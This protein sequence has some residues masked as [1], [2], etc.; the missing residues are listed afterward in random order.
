PMLIDTGNYT[1]P[2]NE[3]EQQLCHIWQAV[4]GLD[5][6]GIHD[7]FFRIGG[8]SINAIRLIAKASTLLDKDFSL[9]ELFTYPTV[10]GLSHHLQ[11]MVGSEVLLI[12]SRD[13]R[14]LSPL[15]FAQERLWFLER[16]EAGSDTYHMPYLVQL[17]ST[18]NAELLLAAINQLAQRHPVLNSVYLEAE[19]GEGYTQERESPLK[20]Q[21]QQ[22]ASKTELEQSVRLEIQTSFNLSEQAPLRLCRYDVDDSRY[23]LLMWHHIAFDGWSTEIFIDELMEFYQ[24]LDA[25]IEPELTELSISYSDF[26]I[27]QR[28]YLQG[29]VLKGQL[30][31]WRA[32]LADIE[33]LN[34]PTDKTR[35]TQVDYCGA[36]FE[37]VLAVSLSNDLRAL[38]R[39]QNT[40]L[41]TVMLSAFYLTLSQLCHQ[42]DIIVGAPSDNRHL[43]QTQ[44]LIGFFVNSLA[45][46][47][48]V[49]PHLTCSDLIAQVDKC[50]QGARI[51]QD[52]PFDK[53]VNELG[54]ERDLSRHPIFQVMFSVQSFSARVKS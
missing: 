35:P 15:S 47:T 16:F 40:T 27:W 9:A 19:S 28:D 36:D 54:V 32:Q 11:V 17:Q 50:V 20:Y 33:I 31:Y 12:P 53:L 29:E 23:L 25:G 5:K 48:Q 51:H 45:L 13:K 34:L 18:T 43:A 1:P 37:Q 52:L 38:A 24:A 41:F 8:N 26:A 30:N 7:N 22:C 3:L 10:A 49:S 46:R 4:L 21:V 39:A 6:V 2:R 42:E 44:S 14:V